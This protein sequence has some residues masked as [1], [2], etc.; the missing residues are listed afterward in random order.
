MCTHRRPISKPATRVD[1]LI[2]FIAR[3]GSIESAH[4]CPSHVLQHNLRRTHIHSIHPTYLYHSP[5]S[6]LSSILILSFSPAFVYFPNGSQ[7][8]LLRLCV[9]H[10]ASSCLAHFPG[11]HSCSIVCPRVPLV[12]YICMCVALYINFDLLVLLFLYC[13]MV[14]S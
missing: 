14:T 13:D 10:H 7:T 11:S 6:S 2:D 5:I 4:I 8:C 12:L 1:S 9:R 3:C